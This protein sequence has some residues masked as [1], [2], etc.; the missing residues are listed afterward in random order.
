MVMVR[1]VNPVDSEVLLFW[2][3]EVELLVDWLVPLF[4]PLE[5]LRVV[6]LESLEDTLWL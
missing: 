3:S 1:R 4:V 5:V 6:L 2:L